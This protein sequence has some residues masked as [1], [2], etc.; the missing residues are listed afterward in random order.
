MAP[1][2]TEA[3]SRWRR[4]TAL[5]S[6]VVPLPLVGHSLLGD[7]RRRLYRAAR[8]VGSN[9]LEAVGQSLQSVDGFLDRGSFRPVGRAVENFERPMVFD[10]GEA[11]GLPPH[12]VNG[13]S[14]VL[15]IAA[16][17]VASFCVLAAVLRSAGF[18]S[19]TDHPAAVMYPMVLAVMFV[20]GD[21]YSPL[22]SY[23][24]VLTASVI[25]V[26]AT[27]LWVARDCEM[28]AR[29][30][31]WHEPIVMIAFGAALAATYV[32][33]YLAPPFAGA[34]VA[35]RAFV[36]PRRC[37]LRQFVRLASV[38]RIVQANP[39]CATC[40]RR[41]VARDRDG[42]GGM[43][44]GRGSAAHRSLRRSRAS[45]A[46]E[47]GSGVGRVAARC[48]HGARAVGQRWA[49]PSRPCYPAPRHHGRDGHSSRSLRPDLWRQ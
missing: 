40:G 33:T 12:A 1:S 37:T 31:S 34:L 30:L 14:R 20:A 26:M 18:G 19:A 42:S 5:P 47:H 11:T 36:N 7:D 32:L 15:L 2:T 48:R 23:T 25:V 27:G 39:E 29:R 38:R 22:T 10:V 9:P 49:R 28:E 35:A 16:V 3:A 44:A 24:T 4:A 13:L 21:H 6:L 17:A 45:A 41:G 46:G 8:Q 43:V